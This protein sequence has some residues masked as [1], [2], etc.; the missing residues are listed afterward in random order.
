MRCGGEAG[1]RYAARLAVKV[2][3]QRFGGP[4]RQV[5]QRPLSTAMY[6]TA[7]RELHHEARAPALCGRAADGTRAQRVGR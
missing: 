3:A 4:L 7:T 5:K 6:G 1:G 2:A